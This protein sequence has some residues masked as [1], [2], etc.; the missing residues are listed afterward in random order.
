MIKNRRVKVPLTSI[1][2][3]LD[4][5]QELLSG[6]HLD[7]HRWVEA[8]KS[9]C[10]AVLDVFPVRGAYRDHFWAIQ[11]LL[12]STLLKIR[13]YDHNSPFNVQGF[14]TEVGRAMPVPVIGFTTSREPAYRAYSTLAVKHL[15]RY[16]GKNPARYHEIPMNRSVRTH[17]LSAALT[18]MV[19]DY[20]TYRTRNTNKSQSQYPVFFSSKSPHLSAN[21]P[22]IVLSDPRMI[23]RSRLR[24]LFAVLEKWS[25][26]DNESCVGDANYD[27]NWDIYEG[28]A[29]GSR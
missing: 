22:N 25:H 18:R 12:S 6:C 27:Y 16:S 21:V 2:S 17:E 10:C 8:L 24:Q 5:F 4:T 20:H 3:L 1:P 23:T 15:L 7:D 13:P 9:Q 14:V 19:Q 11:E 28:S 29:P 26:P